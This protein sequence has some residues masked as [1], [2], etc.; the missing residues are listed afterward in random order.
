[1]ASGEAKVD[2]V[3]DWSRVIVW[4]Y[5]TFEAIFKDFVR[6]VAGDGKDFSFSRD[7]D[8]TFSVWWAALVDSEDNWLIASEP[9]IMGQSKLET[10]EADSNLELLRDVLNKLESAGYTVQDFDMNVAHEEAT[11]SA[12]LKKEE[13]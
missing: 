7:K 5:N 2:V 4:D 12:T 6:A 1:M 13:A 11:F 10:V 3:I 9:E 8:A